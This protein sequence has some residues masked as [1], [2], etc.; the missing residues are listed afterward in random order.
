M[1]FIIPADL[2]TNLILSNQKQESDFQQVG[3]LLTR[4]R[5]VFLFIASRALLRSYAEFNR[6]L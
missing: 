3:G 4:N 1:V 6:L 5:S 2:V